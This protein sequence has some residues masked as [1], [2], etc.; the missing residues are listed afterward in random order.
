MYIIISSSNKNNSLL[1]HYE[2]LLFE[3]VNICI[4]F[5]TEQGKKPV[6]IH[7][8]FWLFIPSNSQKLKGKKKKIGTL[9]A[10]LPEFCQ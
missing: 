4:H 7:F 2:I 3:T 1:I 10:L 5:V 8:L 9:I 6:T